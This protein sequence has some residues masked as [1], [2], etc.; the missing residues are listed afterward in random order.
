[1]ENTLLKQDFSV[2][3]VDDEILTRQLLEAK[4][5]ALPN[6]SVLGMPNGQAAKEYLIN[7][8]VD[9]V[10]TDIRMPIMGGLELAEFIS[11]FCPHTMVI[12]LSGFGEFDYAKQAIRL[13]VK[14]YLL[15][16]IQSQNLEDIV[17]KCK[18]ETELN[19]VLQIKKGYNPEKD[20]EQMLESILKED[21][22]DS[23]MEELEQLFPCQGTVVTL[24]S[25]ADDKNESNELCT[26]YK[27][28]I[29][30]VV[31]NQTVIS[32]GYHNG[33][34]RYLII[35][36]AAEFHRNLE[37]IGEYLNRIL[38]RE[39]RFTVGPTVGSVKDLRKLDL[40]SD[41]DFST[42]VIERACQF[43][44]EHLGEAISRNMVAEHVFLSHSYFGHLFKQVKGMRYN[45]YLTEMRIEQA[46]KLLQK[47]MMVSDV[48]AA[49]GYRDAKYFSEIFYE[50]T[51]CFPSD[52][53]FLSIN[54][55]A[56]DEEA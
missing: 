4:L 52:Y 11:Q 42:Q 14:E 29:S 12:I 49:V 44:K 40:F 24:N 17:L 45:A 20:L 35:P 38:A 43:M 15:K 22:S 47:N 39:I 33:E 31:R 41:N 50:K 18:Q 10:I 27:N 48:A 30:A 53:K 37:A 28:L 36:R 2:L 9:L 1:M 56:S 46:K 7:H 32:L 5:K 25:I 23:R 8:V 55:V 13:G 21:S 19:R 54:E 26:A 34:Y 3:L 16:P 51:G 6:V